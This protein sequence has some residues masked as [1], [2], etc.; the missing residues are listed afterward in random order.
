MIHVHD[1]INNVNEYEK[2]N[3][4]FKPKKN[5]VFIWCLEDFDTHT[6]LIKI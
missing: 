1:H 5:N 2:Y 4:L 6:C 3:K